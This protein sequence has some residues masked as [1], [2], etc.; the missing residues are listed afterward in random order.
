M[1]RSK[2]YSWLIKLIRN[3]IT[4]YR[5]NNTNIYNFNET[6][7]IIGVILTIIVI[8]SLEGRIKVKKI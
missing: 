4:K 3:I 1:R 6:G 5:I 7:F 2:S 8:I